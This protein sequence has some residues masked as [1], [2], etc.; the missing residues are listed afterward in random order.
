VRRNLLC[1][2]LL[3]CLFGFAQ[4]ARAD[5]PSSSVGI[6]GWPQGY[7]ELAHS[8]RLHAGDD[9]AWAQPGVDDSAWPAISLDTPNDYAGWI[10][11]RLRVEL[12][13]QHPPLSL[14]VTGGDGTY[15][16]YVNGERL[17]GPR[18]RSSLLVSYPRSR[19]VPLPAVTGNAVIALRTFIPPTSMF[20]ANRGAFRVEVGTLP[21]IDRARRAALST[22]LDHVILDVGFHMLLLLA[23]IWS[24]IL[25]W[26]QRDHRE[27]FWLGLYLVMDA[28]GTILYEVA[29]FSFVPF[30]VNWFYS[31]PI[32]Y[33]ATI[34]QIEFTFRFVGQRVARPW[35]IY[36][37]ILAIPPIFL[38]VPAW[39][40]VLSRGLFNVDEILLIVPAAMGMPILLFLWYRRGYKEAAWLIFPSLLPM[41]TVALNDVGIVGSWLGS[42]FLST[43]GDPLPLGALSVE[44]FDIADTLFLL[45]IGIV[46]FFRFTRVSRDQARAAA[47]LEAAR[48]IQQRLVPLSLPVI[49]GCRIQAAYLP[50]EEVGGDFYQV[51]E[52]PGG[53]TLI[54][55]GDVSGKGLKAAM[56]GALVLGAIRSLAQEHLSPALILSR[57][58]A[59]LSTP[60][61]EGFVT[62]LVASV[63]PDGLFT[64]ANAGHLAPYRNGEE[65]ALSGGLPLGI[66]PEAEYA[67]SALSLAPGDTLTFLSDGVVEAQ[68]PLGELFGFDRTCQI[69][70]LS[71]EQIAAK[72]QAHGQ[73]DDITV[74]SLTFAPAEVLG[75]QG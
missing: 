40:N 74:L 16:I 14:L 3:L 47:E 48:T 21:A 1:L 68:S 49:P 70:T 72:A 33:F 31:V 69:S 65:I 57:L 11:Y 4:G 23:G 55:I 36:E 59:Q 56:T 50:A 34:A 66:A 25:F 30:A 26:Y 5:E 60:A 24:L 61:E 15:E 38:V 37:W 19:V 54:V 29:V 63:E 17:P 52:Q 8:W 13:P 73:Q 9:L 44:P 53:S 64:I 43:V 51:L 35:R 10:W 75:V 18:L 27:Y 32:I 41:L 22:R 45:A 20:L 2:G 7:V 58:N 62:C 39:F 6:A 67:E 28:S 12:P 71:A 46:M 42:Q